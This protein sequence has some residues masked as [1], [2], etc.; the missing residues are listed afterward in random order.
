MN[1]NGR[2]S[3]SSESSSTTTRALKT[4]RLCDRNSPL[5][6]NN[7]R[8]EELKGSIRLP[9]SAP[10]VPTMPIAGSP[11][12]AAYLGTN[13]SLFRSMNSLNANSPLSL[14]QPPPPLALCEANLSADPQ[15]ANL[16]SA[17]RLHLAERG[18]IPDQHGPI[19]ILP[20]SMPQMQ[21]PS[22]PTLQQANSVPSI[23]SASCPLPASNVRLPA[24]AGVASNAVLQST[25]VQSVPLPKTE[26]KASPHKLSQQEQNSPT[27]SSAGSWSNSRIRLLD[28]DAVVRRERKRVHACPYDTCDKVYTKSSHLKAHVRTHTGTQPVRKTIA[29]NSYTILCEVSGEKPYACSWEGC[30]WKFARSDE[31]TRH[32]RKHTGKWYIFVM[33]YFFSQ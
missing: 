33:S 8:L 2:K 28:D 29:F 9:L 4:M 3:A 25:D 26:A 15:T 27:G 24:P 14:Q 16:F 23:S 1:P 5:E 31:L 22:A 7:N 17:L 12:S 32:Y 18:V 20:A 10:I 30:H 11:I 19:L 21:S 6:Q 13:A